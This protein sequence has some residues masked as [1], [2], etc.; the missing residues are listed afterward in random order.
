M[1]LVNNQTSK[2]YPNKFLSGAGMVFQFCR[3][4]DKFLDENYAF[5]YIDL[6]A[7]GICGDMMSGLEVENQFFWKYGFSHIEN[8]FLKVL[9]EKQ[10]FSMKGQINPI[11]VAFYIVP[12]LNAMIRVGSKD[13]K[14]RLFLAIVEGHTLVANN[15]RGHKGQQ[16]EVAIESA[17]ECTNAKNHQNKE[18]EE[19]VSRLEGKIAEYGL[20]DNQILFIRLEDDDVFPPELNGLVAMQLASKYKRPTIVARLNP[21]GFIR[22]SSRG[23][24]NSELESFKAFMDSTGLFEYTAG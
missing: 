18:K 6:A 23:L 8:Y 19:I 1:I 15:A 17:R 4:L 2:N 11:T 12:M 7:V 10:S 3:A 5:D 16:I 22:G 21:Q 14:Q 20:L 9:C 13:E 24:N